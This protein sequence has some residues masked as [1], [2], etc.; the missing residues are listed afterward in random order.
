MYKF[1]DEV[2]AAF[3]LLLILSGIVLVLFL[4]LMAIV[5]ATPSAFLDW[6]GLAFLAWRGYER[7]RN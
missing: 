5:L 4:F 3:G 1:M 6:F 7:F 2:S